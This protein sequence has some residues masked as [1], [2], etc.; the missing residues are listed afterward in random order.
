MKLKL[1]ANNLDWKSLEKRVVE[2]EKHLTSKY[3]N[4]YGKV[5]IDIDHT[6]FYVP[7]TYLISNKWFMDNIIG[8]E[9]DSYCLL[10]DRK[11]W[12]GQKDLL[13]KYEK[14]KNKLGFYLVCGEKEKVLRADN[15][16]YI[17]FEEAFEHE[18]FHAVYSDLGAT[19]K[20]E[21]ADSMYLPGFDNTHYFA[22]KDKY[23]IEAIYKEIYERWDKKGA[24]ISAIIKKL[25]DSLSQNVF[26]GLVKRKSDELIIKMQ[27]LGFPIIITE[28]YRS[29]QR[30]NE[31]Y[32]Q[33]RTKP[34]Q[35]VTNA[36]AGESFHNYGVAFDCVF[37][38]EG[39]NA[40]EKQWEILGKE[41]EKL[42]L[43]WGGRWV[44]FK[45]R[46]HFQVTLGYTLADFKTGKVDYSK[47]K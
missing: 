45:D 9:Y 31:L 29:F 3:E 27:S 18:L 36:K 46:P 32:A 16:R 7:E 19:L 12:K 42:G 21:W 37:K 39:Y 5:E 8:T 2:L 43:E 34:G 38:K 4:I 10:I 23:N 13:G 44:S 30:Q 1:Y 20:W 14:G 6:S 35:I 11:D 22:Y 28:T 41:G 47:F 17:A 33:G 26:Y 40:T 25:Q 24:E 15:V